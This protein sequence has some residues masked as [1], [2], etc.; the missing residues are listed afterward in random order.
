MKNFLLSI[1]IATIFLSACSSN[2]NQKSAKDTTLDHKPAVHTSSSP[3]QEIITAYLQLKNALANDDDRAAA[4]AGNILKLAVGKVTLSA[5]NPAQ[6]KNFSEIAGD[7]KE[8]GEHIGAN[9]GNIKHQREHFEMLSQEIYE[10]AKADGKSG[11]KLYYAHCP[12]YN[13][14]KGGNW[15]SETKVIKNPYLGKEMSS[16]GSIR[17][18]L[19]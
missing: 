16:C 18:E 19:N 11:Q 5:L 15:I 10:L 12:M 14:K 4:D 1:A 3:T 8:H 9:A 7:V 2:S 13:N 17:E 6:S